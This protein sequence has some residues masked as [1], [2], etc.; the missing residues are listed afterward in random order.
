MHPLAEII[1]EELL[2]FKCFNNFL[3]KHK[4][5]PITCL[6]YC[7]ESDIKYLTIISSGFQKFIA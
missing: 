4:I 3:K 6:T 2:I 1:E 5:T 7:F